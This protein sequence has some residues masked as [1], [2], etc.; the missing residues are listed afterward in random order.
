MF[1]SRQAMLGRM[2]VAHC[3]G[4]GHRFAKHSHDEC[5]IGVNL[6]GVEEVWLDRRTF[7]AQPGDI[8]LYNPGQIQGGGVKEGEPWRFAGLY[9]CADQL[10]ADFGLAHLEFERACWRQPR[11]GQCLSE[12]VVLGLQADPHARERAEERLLEALAHLVDACAARLPRSTALGRG[13][14]ARVQALLAD[15]LQDTPDLEEMAALVGVS[16]FHLLRAFQKET[17]LSPR[18]WAM[19]LRTCRARGLLRAG[20]P[21]T[22][23][24]HALGFAD[25]SHLNRHFRAAYG[26]TPGELGRRLRGQA[27]I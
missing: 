27:A 25:Q 17:G 12:A 26:I 21:A 10:A 22:D 9:L 23:V 6:V 18:Q 20:V 2:E 8:T 5:V 19:Q 1:Y 11:L 7:S 3:S 4:T 14:V 16:R 15:R 24:A 13:P